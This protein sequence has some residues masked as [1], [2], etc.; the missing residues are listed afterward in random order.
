MIKNIFKSS[1]RR[2]GRSKTGS[3]INITCLTVGMTTA[4][5]ILL[6]VQ[7]ELSYD[8]Y[9]SGAKEIFRVTMHNSGVGTTTSE[10]SSLLLADVAKKEIPAVKKTARLFTASFYSPGFI[11]NGERV[12]EKKYAYVDEGWFTL[13][14]H[15]VIDG[16][17][18]AFGQ[19]PFS[20]ILT[21]SAAKKYFSNHSA[22]GKLIQIDSI[23]YEVQAV[24]KDNPANSSF[25]FDIWFPNAAYLSDLKNRRNEE[26]WN[27]GNYLTFIQLQ[28]NA[29]PQIVSKQLNKII[30]RNVPDS[31]A[32]VSLLPLKNIHLENISNSVVA[33]GNSNIIFIFSIMAVLILLTA[34]INYITLTTANAGL[35]AKEVSV[36][37]ILGAKRKH[38]FIQFLVDS[39][40]LSIFAWLLTLVL[41]QL[42]LPLFNSITEKEFML[43]ITSAS[44]WRVLAITFV[45]TLLF[46]SIYPAVLLSG[47]SPLA[48][49]RGIGI[50]HSKKG[51]FHKSLVMVQFTLSIALIISTIVIV[52]QLN[53][54][55]QTDKNYNRSQIF[56]I[57]FPIQYVWFNYT[58]EGRINLA[59]TFKQR[60]LSY[61]AIE[62]VS[63]GKPIID[64]KT[65]TA[66]NIDWEGHD[67]NNH[68]VIASL[69][70]DAEFQKIFNLQMIQGRWFEPGNKADE[71]N[72]ILNETAFSE[73]N[74]H[75]PVSGQRFV[76]GN[77][78][79]KIIGVVKDFHYSSLHSKI[80]PL[81]IHNKPGRQ[82]TFLIKT[83][84]GAIPQAL[85]GAKAEWKKLVPAQPFDYTFMD[86]A[87]DALYRADERTSALVLFF[88]IITIAISALG[89]FGLA[90]FTAEQRVREIG[91]RKVLGA[92][93]TGIVNI[94]SRDFLKIV[95][96]A[97][98]LACPIAWIVMNK[99]LQDFAYRIN[100]SWWIFFLAG[101]VALIIALLAVS[102]QSIKAAIANPVK[103]LR[104][105]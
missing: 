75:N 81:V 76:F 40:L 42:L 12:K 5:L 9:H 92:T 77:D 79:G 25:Q 1:I 80:A 73:F 3:F 96:V 22:V 100:I 49:F 26:S 68:P 91:I 66:D 67:R 8:N 27:S 38:L 64:V 94:L 102:F 78:T 71:H 43:P 50:L 44:M 29:D 13:F 59:T 51:Y 69:N 10:F 84:Q 52:K 95:I 7:N 2:L 32:S 104:T 88:A 101:I 70:T 65:Y 58:D 4:V 98:V 35:R 85:Q 99:W 82:F 34:C 18:I 30:N 15:D 20:L 74:L 57:A 56:S 53:L 48:I 103:S 97:F 87:F 55:R 93:V 31:K 23:N 72:F 28:K 21:R 6:W 46:S 24:I 89:L 41:V 86:E 60:L 105:E 90:A 37:K 61:P 47:F 33:H 62:K 63:I 17:T 36:R 83:S 19:N 14:H 11:Y 39:L 45:V 16:T 54:I